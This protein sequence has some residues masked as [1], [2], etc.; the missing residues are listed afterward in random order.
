MVG[1]APEVGVGEISIFKVGLFY[2]EYEFRMPE[3]QKDQQD[4]SD[5]RGGPQSSEAPLFQ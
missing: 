1:P 5:D 3:D 2:R 4:L